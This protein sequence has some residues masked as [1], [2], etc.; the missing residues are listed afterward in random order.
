VTLLPG[1]TATFMIRT[2]ATVAPEAFLDPLVLRCANQ[3]LEVR[4]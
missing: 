4:A 3:L 2:A 1:E